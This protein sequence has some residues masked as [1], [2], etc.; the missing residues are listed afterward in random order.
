M[1]FSAPKK[2][3]HTYAIQ[4]PPKMGRHTCTCTNQCPPPKRVDKHVSSSFLQYTKTVMLPEDLR[5]RM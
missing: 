3:R 2:G 4:C 1:L 5:T